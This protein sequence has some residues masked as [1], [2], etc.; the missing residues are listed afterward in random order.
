ML[1]G[2]A[3]F[4]AL[5]PATWAGGGLVLDPDVVDLGTVKAGQLFVRQVRVSNHLPVPVAITDVSGSCGCLRM[6]VE[7][8]RIAPKGTA[9]LHLHVNTL[10]NAPGPQA[11]RVT[12]TGTSDQ[13]SVSTTCFVR[14]EVIQEIT[15]VP[16]SV[17][18]SLGERPAQTTLTLTDQRARPLAVRSVSTSSPNVRVAPRPGAPGAPWTADVTVSAD[19]KPGRHE[20]YISIGTDDRDYPVL[21]VPLTINKRAQQRWLVAPVQVHFDA[22]SG[23]RKLVT[24]RDGQGG[25]VS[26]PQVESPPPAVTVAVQRQGGASCTLAVVVGE[27]AAAIEG[28]I[29]VHIAGIP[30]P[31]R[32]PIR[33]LPRTGAEPKR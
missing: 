19:F 9:I 17:T 3:W 26:V 4:L 30:E 8:S 13:G 6:E 23:P 14:A 7:P 24:L 32:I 16:T 27:T 15:L 11:W 33:V 2:L 28:E 18:M 5:A 25:T 12:I 21:I 22:G 31:A 1:L 20:E 10:T 29:V